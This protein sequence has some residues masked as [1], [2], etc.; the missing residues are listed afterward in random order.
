MSS[1]TQPITT[2]KTSSSFETLEV[3]TSLYGRDALFQTCYKFT[4]RCYLFLRQIDSDTVVVEIRRRA[5]SIDL[6][7]IVGEFGNELIDQRLRADI[8]RSTH[9][10]REQI[11]RQAFAEG[12]L[13]QR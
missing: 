2:L 12:D 13:A 3:N 7:A 8:A 6:R 4:D 11:V 5:D 9:D 10:I 1:Y